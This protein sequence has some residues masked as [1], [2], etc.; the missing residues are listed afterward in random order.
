M[1]NNINRKLEN[2]FFSFMIDSCEH[3]YNCIGTALHWIF[4]H[5][6]DEYD[7]MLVIAH[8]MES[9]ENRYK[10]IAHEYQTNPEMYVKYIKEDYTFEKYVRDEYPNEYED[11]MDIHS[12]VSCIHSVVYEKYAA[13]EDYPVPYEEYKIVPHRPINACELIHAYEIEHTKQ[14]YADC[15]DEELLLL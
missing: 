7:T 4:T 2:R 12:M 3:G 6:P 1:T 5:N 11:I 8:Q 10:E 15:P 14:F 9:D 13:N